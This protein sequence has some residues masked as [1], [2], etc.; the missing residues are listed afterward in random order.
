MR[1]LIQR[2]IWSAIRI[3]TLQYLYKLLE[4]FGFLQ[5]IITYLTSI[6]IAAATISLYLM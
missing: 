6:W 5:T 3:I 2:G 4:R 1:T